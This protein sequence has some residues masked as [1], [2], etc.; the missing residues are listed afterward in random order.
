[1]DVEGQNHDRMETDDA[2]ETSGLGEGSRQH[3]ERAA[4]EHPTELPVVLDA[5]AMDTT[6]DHPE[7]EEV[8]Q[9]SNPRMYFMISFLKLLELSLSRRL[10]C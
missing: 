10:I 1:M 2:S 4:G 3:H 6:P 9:L 8:R 5:E 7:P